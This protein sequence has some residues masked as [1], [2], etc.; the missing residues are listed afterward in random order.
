M[1]GWSEK[2]KEKTVSLLR[3]EYKEERQEDLLKKTDTNSHSQPNNN[4]KCKTFASHVFGYPQS[5]V[6]IYEELFYYL[7]ELK[8]LQA[9]SEVDPFE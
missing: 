7:D 4:H 5:Q 3:S 9:F 8:T 1:H 6:P 2:L